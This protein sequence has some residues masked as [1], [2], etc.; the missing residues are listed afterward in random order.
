MTM[1]LQHTRLVLLSQR[2]RSYRRF[3]SSA[4][5]G[6]RITE[7]PDAKK[8]GNW[9]QG[10]V[11]DMAA[12]LRTFRPGDK[13]DIPYEMT[14]SES[15]QDFWQSVRMSVCSQHF[16]LSRGA[17]FL[18]IFFVACP[19][20]HYF[21]FFVFFFF[22]PGLPCPRSHSYVDPLLSKNGIA[23]SGLALFV[24]SLFDVQYDA[25]RCRQDPSR[26]WQGILFVAS[27]CGRYLYQDVYRGFDSE[28]LGW[29]SCGE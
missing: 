2:R 8:A 7:E 24:G 16:H 19:P 26:V 5:N 18:W 29:K 13:L 27:L 28:Y 14:V 4:V 20:G 10:Q 3:L 22:S 12:D 9:I 11:L 1:L 25:C 17:S 15:M 21:F 6:F 23:R